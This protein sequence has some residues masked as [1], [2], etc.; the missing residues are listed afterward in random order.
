MTHNVMKGLLGVLAFKGMMD[1]AGPLS[2]TLGRR[3]RGIIEGL[4]ILL[5]LPEAPKQGFF[6]FLRINC[7]ANAPAVIHGHQRKTADLQDQGL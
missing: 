4:D 3:A 2:V 1:V 5:D 6:H 7:N